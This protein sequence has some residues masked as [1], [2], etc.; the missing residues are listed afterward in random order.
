MTG[1]TGWRE[2]VVAKMVVQDKVGRRAGNQEGRVAGVGRKDILE[3]NGIN[4]ANFI[5][6]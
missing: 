6:D 3:E 1:V 4:I 5:C 2:G